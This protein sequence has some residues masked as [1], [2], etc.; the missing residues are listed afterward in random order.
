[1][2]EQA[3]G[4]LQLRF[5]RE[6]GLAAEIAALV[7]PALE[8]LRYR[9]VRVQVLGRDGQT[10]QIMAERPDGTMTVEDCEA[11]SRQ[12]SPLLDAHDPL[13]GS[14]RLEISSPGID[15]VLVRPSDFEDWAGHKAKI[16]LKEPIGGRKRLRGTIEGLENGLV[17][18]SPEAAGE[19]DG[20][21]LLPLHAIAEAKLILTDELIRD[22]LRRAK[23][24]K[25]QGADPQARTDQH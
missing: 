2:R 24:A 14:Y 9:L 19:G 21:L 11:I 3:A 7:E 12:I 10:V 22:A 13:P 17:R 25:R 1:M 23:K 20:L 6:T 4:E 15:R 8:D 16:M 18:F 5:I